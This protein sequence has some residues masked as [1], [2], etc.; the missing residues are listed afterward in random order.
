MVCAIWYFVLKAVLG[1]GSIVKVFTDRL[2]SCNPLHFLLQ[3][4]LTLALVPCPASKHEEWSRCAN[5][6]E[7][8]PPDL[9]MN[10]WS[11]TLYPS[12]LFNSQVIVG[13]IPCLLTLTRFYD[14]FIIATTKKNDNDRTASNP[15][16]LLDIE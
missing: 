3:S 2:L 7:N 13:F 4:V 10:R 14:L 5:N 9:S 1:N 12:Y 6:N 15:F 8:G 11:S 16:R